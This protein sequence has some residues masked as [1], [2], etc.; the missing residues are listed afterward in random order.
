MGELIQRDSKWRHTETNQ[1]VVVSWRKY[2]SWNHRPGYP[3]WII[4]FQDI[5]RQGPN[6][7]TWVHDEVSFLRD[8][9]KKSNHT[10]LHPGQSRHVLRNISKIG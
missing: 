6:Y 8:S 4:Y 10:V 5:G 1:I 9:R 2:E 3:E 7:H